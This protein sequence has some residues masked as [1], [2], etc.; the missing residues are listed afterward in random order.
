LATVAIGGSAVAGHL[1]SDV[2][3]YTGCLTSV[4]GTLTLIR[5]GNTPAKPCPKGSVEA[6]FSGG[7]ITGVTA[8]FGL[9]GGG[10]NG[11]VTLALDPDYAL[12]QDCAGG[13]VVKWDATDDAWGCAEDDDTTY[14]AGTGLTLSGTVFS[15]D[16]DYALPDC[17]LGDSATVVSDP[18]SAF[19]TWGCQQKADANQDCSAGEFVTGFS[20]TGAVECDDAGSGAAATGQVYFGKTVNPT[21]GG[22]ADDD[23]GIPS[24]DTL[25]TYASVS[26]SAGTYLVTVKG[27][28]ESEGTAC[29]SVLAGCDGDVLHCGLDDWADQVAYH[30][31][32][33]NED[34]FEGTF[35]LLDRRVT[36]GGTIALICN[37]PN[38]DGLSIHQVRI[39]AQKIG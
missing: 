17:S 21:Q 11:G 8:G 13:Q 2:R 7:D 29:G 35:T 10:T 36:T 38:G 37:A 32:T 30:D 20:A 39:A 26:V 28:L 34:G 9:T 23:V 22:I 15:V 3:S 18:Q 16:D 25:R 5:E 24:D 6:H 12:R 4:G 19:G 33:V 1:E 14:T 31:T 27:R